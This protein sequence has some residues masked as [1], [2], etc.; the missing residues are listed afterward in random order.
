MCPPNKEIYLNFFLP[1]NE[2]QVNYN[3]TMGQLTIN[4]EWIKIIVQVN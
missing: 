1:P 4:Q 2:L 3:L